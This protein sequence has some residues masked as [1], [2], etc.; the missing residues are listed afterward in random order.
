MYLFLP[1]LLVLQL[2]AGVAR[3][4]RA[5]GEQVTFDVQ[6]T[7]RIAIVGA[8]AAGIATVKAIMDLDEDLRRGWDVVVFEERAGV[9]GLWRPDTKPVPS[10]PEI[11]ET[12]LYH[13]LQTNGPHPHMTLPGTLFRPETELIPIHQKVLLYHEDTVEDFNLSPYIKLE[14]SVLETKWVGTSTEGFWDILVEDRRDG[15]LQRQSFDHLVVATGCNRYPHYADLVGEDEWLAANRTLIHSMYYRQSDAFAGQNVVVVGA[16][17][18]G[19]D[20]AARL[21]EHTNSTY[22]ARDTREE[23]PDAPGFPVPSGCNGRPRISSVHANGTVRFT[24][25][26]EAQNVHSII[27]AT[28]YDRRVP[29]LT[30][31]GLLD[32]V[33]EHT[34]ATQRLATNNRYLRP[35]YEHTLSLDPTYP[36]GALYFNGL[37]SY[38]P[39]GMCNYAQGLFVAYTIARPELLDS[40]Q[41]L[42]D[43]LVK[44]EQCVREAGFDPARAGHRPLGYRNCEHTWFED[45]MINYLKRHGLAGSPGVPALD[46]NYTTTRREQTYFKAFDMLMAWKQGIQPQGEEYVRQ[47]V[48]G[49]E[50]EEDWFQL[51][52]KLIAWWDEHKPKALQSSFHDVPLFWF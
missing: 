49:R 33:A 21:V 14:H 20:I 12:P 34:N 42:R 10:P 46:V 37:L 28:G 40:R 3:A 30:S 50:T 36:L 2:G 26:T 51:M 8:G 19:W 6:P 32:E 22:W 35:V 47:W 23:N 29:F 5:Y 9:G 38:N 11:P 52:E 48:E 7:K 44:R 41:E 39:T 18:S 43:A 1:L 17:P 25:G 13:N 15:T 27:L 24:D 45:E 31:A 4:G 16:G